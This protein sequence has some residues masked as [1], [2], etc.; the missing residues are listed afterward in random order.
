MITTNR[1]AGQII[2]EK[3]D[4]YSKSN[5][6]TSA[7]VLS[8]V[9]DTFTVPEGG[10]TAVA[11]LTV[12]DW[13]KLSIS[14]PGG[15][16]ELDLTSA[17]D[18][19]G[20]M[21]GHQEWSKTDSFELISGEYTLMVTHENVELPSGEPNRSVC[22]YSVTV[23]ANGGG[24]SSLS[25]SGSSSSATEGN[26]SSSSGDGPSSSSFG[27]SSS[28]SVSGPSSSSSYSSSSSHSS[29][30]GQNS[31]SPSSSFN[32]SSSSSDVPPE[33]K[34]I[35]CKC[36]SCKDAEGNEY[37]IATEKLPGDPDKEICMPLSEFKKKG[38]SAAP[39]P[40][41]AA[42]SLRSV[43]AVGETAE[44]CG[45]LKYVS[46]WAWRANLDSTSGLITILPPTGA[47][48]YFSL[49]AGSD[50]ALPSGISRKRDFRVQLLDESLTPCT[51]ESPVFLSLVD[52]DGQKVRFSV[53]TGAVVSMTSSS[54]KVVHADDY[55]Q[56]VK[57]TYD[58]AGNLVSSYTA[59]EGLMRTRT[60]EK[61]ALVMEWY[62]P[63][64]VTVLEDGSYEVSG[65]PYKTSSYESSESEGVSTTVITR[66]QR[67]LPAHAITR[68][69]EPG[70]IT[71]T[72]GTGDDTIIRTIETN[73][74][75]GG[76]V[77]RIESVKGINDTE[78]V[79][80]NRTVK[81]YT[82]GGWLTVNETEAF[83]TPL[84]RT[85]TYEYNGQYRVSRVNSPDGGYTRYEYDDEGRVILQAE[86]WVGGKEKM[87]RTAYADKR[88]Y[89]N[90]PVQVMESFLQDNG[91][92][93][94]LSTKTYE[95]EDS[96]LVEKVT[97]T[98]TA[99]GS[100][101]HQVSIQE[102][103]GEAAAYPYAAGKT[104]FMQN[105]DGI[106][107]WYDYEEADE[108]GAVHKCTVT[109]MVNAE[110]VPGQSTK[111][112]S[113][114]A[115]DGT[116]ISE[117]KFIWDGNKWLLLS[118]VSYEYD[119]QRRRIKTTRG[120][121]RISTTVWM[122]SGKLSETDEDGITTTY[123]YNTAGQLVE[124][125]RSEVH[126]GDTVVT[127]ET[128]VSYTCDAAGRTLQ[129]RRD[130]GAMT[131]LESSEYDSL[132]RTVSQTDVL[133][134]V[135]TTGYSDNG[136]TETVTTPSGAVLVTERHPDGSVLHVYGT[137][138][139]ELYH[140]YD[141]SNNC[142]EE[143]VTLADKSNI[144]SRTLVNGF[145][146]NILQMAPTTV[147]FLYDRSEY[148]EKGQLIRT[149]RDTGTHE[150]AV[151]MAP[152]LYEYDSF[153]NVTKQTL[154]LAEDPEPS[155]SP[156]QKSS[157]S[158]ENTEEGVFQV[159]A[160]TR[161]NAQG[162]PL[163]TVR[164]QLIS[165]MS[166]T[167]ESKSVD[168]NER[169]LISTEWKEYAVKT[170][171]IKKSAIPASGITAE[172]VFV[173]GIMLSKKD[174]AG[175]ITTTNRVFTATGITLTQTDARGNATISQ[176][177]IAGR[178]VT[179]TDAAG[180]STG[181]AY[182]QPFNQPTIVTDS[183]GN[184]V[185][186]RYD[187]RGRKVAEWGTAIQ[188]ALFEYDSMDHMISLTTFRVRSET[189]SGDPDGRTDG[190]TTI[191][192]YHEASGLEISKSYADG[193]HI[194]KTYNELGLLERFCN[195]RGT[196]EILEYDTLTG[197]VIRVTFSD[198]SVLGRTY[199]YNHLG[200]L[201]QVIDASGTRLIG[202][203]K[204][205]EQKTDN[206][207]SGGK[208]HLVME[209]RDQLGRSTGYTYAKDGMVEQTVFTGYGEGGRITTAGFLH[210]GEE[211]QFGFSYLEGT[212]LLQRL[213]KPNGM[214]FT[215]IYEEKRDVVAG[216][217]YKKESMDIVGREYNYDSLGRPLDR[218]TTRNGTVKNDS[219]SHNSRSE[220]TGA[221]VNGG[222]YSYDYDNIGNR[223]SAEEVT[224]ELF[225]SADSLNQYTSIQ[226][227]EGEPFIPSFDADGNQTLVETSTGIWE[228][229]Y[230]AEN[231]PVTFT[232]REN[233]IRTVIACKYDYLGRRMSK[234]V[235][236][237]MTDGEGNSTTSTILDQQ[238]IYRGYLQI[239]CCD[240]QRAAHPCLWLIIWDPS[241]PIAARPLAIRMDGTWYTY[242][243]DM[244]K[245]VWEVFD[246]S[247][248]I[249]SAYNYTPY[250]EV[251]TEGDVNQPIQWSS[252]FLDDELGLVY[253]NYRHYN[254]V[255]GR[256]INRDPV[257]NEGGWNLS[258]YV[259][260][261]PISLYDE[262]GLLP[263]LQGLL[264]EHIVPKVG[265]ISTS[266][267][268]IIPLLPPAV[269][270]EPSVSISGECTFCC[271]P[272]THE[273]KLMV[274]VSISGTA[275]IGMGTSIGNSGKV[276]D[277]R[278][279]G[280]KFRDKK[281][282]RTA[283]TPDLKGSSTE[284]SL[285]SGNINEE[286]PDY[287]LDGSVTVGVQGYV[288]GGWGR[289]SIGY[290][291]DANYTFSFQEDP[292]GGFS[293]GTVYGRGTGARISGYVTLSG[294]LMFTVG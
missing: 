38:G 276:Y 157:Y 250:G 245:N 168:I 138:Q 257:D 117:R 224:K 176:I 105:A 253:Y 273:R 130:I 142:L 186:Y 238:Y 116:V 204:Y 56:Q 195:A 19:P 76:M 199:T 170:K 35:C 228:V 126:D 220:L 184:T 43:R 286:C 256:W 261:N 77:E 49:R 239:A 115:S 198:G 108:D 169:N 17:A 16:F 212:N 139:R 122:C 57:N 82:D 48:L 237:T 61:G 2:Y 106:Q 30:S 20:E 262:L 167:L 182:G 111:K 141:I 112:E 113:F 209:T 80:C 243:L 92:E 164:K 156:V 83:K 59:A 58:D 143:T 133:G 121:G 10:A 158:V 263:S 32:S 288:S 154:A 42:F 90:R 41:P 293:Y 109:S 149:Q 240:L 208:T 233:N 197:Q 13:G 183:F 187:C 152:T 6:A 100:S 36:G 98:I 31:S 24:G 147:G 62:A 4:H 89:D 269:T 221:T 110:L 270:L 99:A 230:N 14:G 65:T 18:D 264:M 132:G 34:E 249:R 218:C 15:T 177:D 284:G 265:T 11:S 279:R 146:Q 206:L 125:I 74:L 123:G 254:P 64:A 85:T 107:T 207:A 46:P 118:S 290:G 63:S 102:T 96:P 5:D 283:K 45:A 201:I 200:Q 175:V 137:G 271:H 104:K 232:K 87:I 3:S 33:D 51:A 131:S 259:G 231:R 236:V 278:L 181:Y 275:D 119:E 29:S 135:T 165:Q 188:P 193:T 144:V 178:T 213:T 191:W 289:F 91:V 210:E 192:S 203:N 194:D 227:G 127:P 84:A 159:T 222:G 247:G 260:N 255:E 258:S 292:A 148:D 114:T 268:W 151:L 23:T 25:S 267:T 217:Y 190:D 26:T 9:S 248:C 72:K 124:T 226:E 272:L 7:D 145:G 287:L 75:Y 163:A 202:Y 219:F 211:K 171:R 173:D 161:Y 69:E 223:K 8:P 52:E 95:Y 86:P 88:F 172:A 129:T 67:G 55:F 155:N 215:Q 235:E 136:L 180:N 103:Y 53:E 27:Y 185:N 166:S 281:T 94:T 189:V 241:Q 79:S 47:A 134:R 266:F 291:F 70:K 244:T 1:N 174:H 101:Q 162:A 39:D 81:Q 246:S 12:D 196:S 60:G 280:S 274:D 214:I 229:A 140:E 234:K 68:M 120:N 78:P 179:V 285:M 28:S 40:V 73:R 150:D 251:S 54:G 205:G 160:M 225:Y 282:G 93:I 242:G 22:I 37:T 97:K 50:T 294:D 277:P 21:G 66:Q 44:A 153:G 216:M 252:E 71:I 128:I